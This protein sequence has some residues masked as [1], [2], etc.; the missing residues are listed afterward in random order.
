MKKAGNHRESN[1]EHPGL[2]EPPTLTILYIYCMGGTEVPQLHTRQYVPSEP[3]EIDQKNLSI[4]TEP[5][6]P[7]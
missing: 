4:K 5:I 6:F 7:V 1:P 3:L 2:C